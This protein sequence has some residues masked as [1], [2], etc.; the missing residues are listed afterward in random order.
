MLTI[1]WILAL[2]SFIII[3]FIIL[4]NFSVLAVLDV[5]NIPG[6][7][8]S[9]FKDQ[10][11]KKR[12]E[13][14]F[15]NILKNIKKTRNFLAKLLVGPIRYFYKSLL[16]KREQIRSLK[17]TDI[18]SRQELIAKHRQKA[19][20]AALE[21]DYSQAEESLIKII[22]LDNKNIE[23]F[24]DLGELYQEKRDYKNS[25]TS[26]EHVLKIWEQLQDIEEL[27]SRD[28]LS[29]AKIRFDIAQ[30]YFSLSDIDLAIEYT[31]Q[32]LDDEPNN[33]RYLDLILDLAIIKKD[34]F[35]ASSTWEKLADVDPDNQK[36]EELKIKI[37]EI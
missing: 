9:K 30:N 18:K 35:L 12:L 26:L 27:S 20:E 36:L 4:R 21:E 32:A 22:D 7:K 34:K 14:D 10:I 31:N 2:I 23:A 25:N 8:E 24:L 15:S 1:A 3:I 29:K 11:M 6:A 37:D 33:P 16:N 17:R 28:G 5:D 19:K 13:R